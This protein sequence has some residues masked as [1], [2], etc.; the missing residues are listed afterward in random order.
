MQIGNPFYDVLLF[1]GPPSMPSTVLNRALDMTSASNVKTWADYVSATGNPYNLSL[2]TVPESP[3]LA[4]MG[5]SVAC[6]A[7]MIKTYNNKIVSWVR[8]LALSDNYYQVGRGVCARVR[9][10]LVLVTSALVACRPL[11]PGG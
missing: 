5:M 11:T 10:S 8:T 2:P 4:A 6:D 7:V 1:C 3:A 9:S